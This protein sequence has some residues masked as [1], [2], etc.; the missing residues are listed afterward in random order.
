MDDYLHAIMCW[1][2]GYTAKRTLDR[3]VSKLTKSDDLRD[4]VKDFVRDLEYYR[5]SYLAVVTPS[6]KSSLSEDLK[7]LRGLNV[8]SHS[9]LTMVHRHCQSKFAEA[10]NLVL[11]LQI[12]NVTIGPYQANRYEKNWRE[13]AGLV[14][15]G[16]IDAAF[17]EIRNKLVSD[18]DF[19]RRFEKEEVVSPLT[20]RH[21]LRRLDPI[22]QPGSGVL[23]MDVDV[24][25]VLPKSLLNKLK[26][27]KDIKGNAAQWITDL[28]YEIPTSAQTKSNLA[29]ELGPYLNRL[30]NQALLND[31]ANRG[32]RDRPFSKKK[33]FYSKQALELT[34]QLTK[35]EAWGMEEVLKRQK[36][37]AEMAPQIW[38]K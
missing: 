21:V 31:R 36:A 6:K 15:E 11:S 25:H 4:F 5:D 12:R 22:S 10:V 24:E 1:R 37:L 34:K 8:Q 16:N 32:A 14:R 13:W 30:G 38:P 3:F 2:E 7:D 18:N 27:N 33:G 23:P 29:K 26:N 35:H 17:T 28:G 9:F 19:K 20:V